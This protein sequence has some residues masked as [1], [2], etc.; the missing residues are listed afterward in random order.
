MYFE[1]KIHRALRLKATASDRSVS[2]LVNDAVRLTLTEDA[3]DL[4]A[5]ETHKREPDLDFEKFVRTLKRRGELQ[6][7]ITGGG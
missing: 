5:F 7:P 4:E 2:D 1:P 3:A 6:A